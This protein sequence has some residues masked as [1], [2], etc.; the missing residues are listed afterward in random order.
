MPAFPNLSSDERTAVVDYVIEGANKEVTGAEPA[1]RRDRARTG[2][3]WI[4]RTETGWV[5]ALSRQLL[6]CHTDFLATPDF[7]IR[8][9]TP[10]LRPPGA[11]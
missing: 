6:L 8:M 4:R 1:A 10:Q 9:D 11:H 3:R 7:S 2:F 5:I